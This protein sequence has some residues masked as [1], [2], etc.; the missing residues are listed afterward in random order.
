MIPPRYRPG[1]IGR[2]KRGDAMTK[3]TWWALLALFVV[4]VRPAAADELDL[5]T[6]D[7]VIEAHINRPAFLTAFGFDS[8]WA[9]QNGV[10][11]RVNAA[12]NSFVEIPLPGVPGRYRG[13]GI[14]EDAVW[15]PDVANAVVHKID[16]ATN[17][18]V[19]SIPVDLGENYNGSIGVGVGSIWVATQGKG[20]AWLAR[21]SAETGEAQAQVKLP[22]SG[23]GVVFDNGAVWVAGTYKKEVYRV[24]AATNTLAATIKTGG[25]PRFLTAAF[26]SIWVVNEQGGA[27]HRI[28]PLTNTVAATIET[29]VSDGRFGDVTGGDGQIWASFAVAPVVQID[30]ATNTMVRR[31]N[32]SGL[33]QSIRYGGGSLWLAQLTIDRVRMPD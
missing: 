9:P 27:V 30:P 3:G 15:I 12:D 2:A 6:S 24:D 19:L 25:N 13:V 22:P 10:L 1:P 5:K 32:G 7:L 21:F 14:G 23:A 16:P 20:A 17:S 11:V 31:F 29:G 28:D 33:G 8:L 4:G 26:G 18:I